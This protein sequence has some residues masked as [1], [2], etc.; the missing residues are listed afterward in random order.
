MNALN[1]ARVL[2]DGEHIVVPAPGETLPVQEEPAAGQPDSAEPTGLVNLNT[3]SAAELETLP[4]VGPA[5]AERI[6]EWRELNGSFSRV[7]E[8]IPDADIAVVFGGTND[9]GTG[10]AAL[11]TIA[12]CTNDTFY[13]ACHL[14]VRKLMEK[15]PNGT[16]VLMTP[17]HRLSEDEVLYNELGVR[18]VGPLSVY[19]QAL[20][21]IAEYYALPLVDLFATCPI[22]PKVDSQREKYMPD[23]LHPNDAGAG[24]I[25]HCL[26]VVLEAL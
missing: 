6:M 5:I 17:L 22:Q 13:G 12:D 18:R 21:D 1:L 14:L 25:A 9:F 23:G 19:V 2:A 16:V 7:D 15:Y 20:R 11:G 4:G 26:Q 10:D 8:L 24:L 3:A